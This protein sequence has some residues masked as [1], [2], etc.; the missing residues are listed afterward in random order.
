MAAHL[1]ISGY[2]LCVTA[3]VLLDITGEYDSDIVA[4]FRMFIYVTLRFCRCSRK[5]RNH[6]SYPW[7]PLYVIFNQ[8]YISVS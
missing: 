7:D 5:Y 8:D 6:V 1:A 3:L 2:I 4:H